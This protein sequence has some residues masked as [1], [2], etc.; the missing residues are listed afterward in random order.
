M[1]ERTRMSIENGF[2]NGFTELQ[3]CS[4]KRLLLMQTKYKNSSF[5][6]FALAANLRFKFPLLQLQLIPFTL[7]TTKYKWAVL[8]GEKDASSNFVFL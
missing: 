7:H 2:I 4:E 8:T 1:K 6:N 3:V 5:P